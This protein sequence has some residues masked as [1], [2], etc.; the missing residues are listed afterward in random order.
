M[1][2]W[3]KSWFDTMEN[4]LQNTSLAR[5]ALWLV[6]L[7]WVAIGALALATYVS[8]RWMRVSLP[9]SRLYLIAELLTAY[10]ASL[11]I[12]VKYWTGRV[13]NG[14]GTRIGQIISFQISADLIIMTTIL[15]Y[16]GGIENPFIFFFVFHMILASILRSRFQSY[17]QA[18]LAILSFG[19]VLLLEA[20]GTIPHYS[21]EGFAGHELYQSR[22][23]VLGC[24]FVLAV[25][26]YLV[27]YMTTSIAEQLRCQQ[28]ELEEANH[29][30]QQKDKIKNQYVLRVT[31]DIKGHL[32]AIQ[33]CLQLVF[34]QIVGPLNEKQKDLT[35]RAYRRTTNCMLFVRTLLKITRLKLTGQMDIS[36]FSLRDCLG[37]A[38]AAAKTRAQDKSIDIHCDIEKSI[39][40]ISGE[41]VYIEETLTNLLLNAV[42]YTPPQGH[43]NI[44]VTDLGD[45]V[46]I[47]FSDTGIGIPASEMPHIFEEFYRASNA[48]ATQRDGTGLG[49]AFA[50]Q[51][52]ERHG[53][54]ITAEQNQPCGT[55]LTVVL[56]KNIP[57]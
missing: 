14:L 17:L 56:P 20:T 34:D 39:E 5:R 57:S 55:V 53:G 49:L 45:H 44:T 47:V 18:T 21:L 6:E 1:L 4:L 8:S 12:L 32:A 24:L 54:T 19:G 41:A 9:D 25:T 50:K 27:V 31:H 13:K 3:V 46:Q 33:S 37:K 11:Y 30:L 7:R 2:L 52:I 28:D 15:H 48:R 22:R 16:A 51:V 23:Y 38:L 36:H 42:K 35:G 29:Q 43:V 26:L 10:N 40:T